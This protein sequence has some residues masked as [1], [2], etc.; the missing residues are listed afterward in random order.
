MSSPTPMKNIVVIG[1]GVVGLTTVV[2]IQEK[3]GFK[4][5]IVAETFPTDANPQAGLCWHATG[6]LTAVD[7]ART[8]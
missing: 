3:G 6:V 1:A 4:V 5:T 2:K 7:A 8:I